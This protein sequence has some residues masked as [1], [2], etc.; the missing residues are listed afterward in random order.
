M[1]SFVKTVE[2]KILEGIKKLGYDT[3]KVL[4]SNSNKPELGQFQFNGVMAIA[5]R[6]GKNPVDLANALVEILKED[7]CFKS[8]SVAGPGF[9]NITFNDEYLINYMNL[10]LDDFDNFIDVEESKTIIIDY[11]GANAAKALHIGHMRSANIGE[12]LKRL[13]LVYKNNVI[14]DVHLGDVGRQSGMVISELQ[15]EQP[16]LPYFKEDYVE[17]NEPLNLTIE[18]LG[19]LYPTASNKAKEDESKMEEVRRITAEVDKGTKRYLD[20]WKKIVEIS[21]VQIKQVYDYL[22]CRFDLWE[23]E[24]DS[25]NYIDDTIKILKPY[26]YESEGAYVIDIKKEDDKLEIPPLIVIKT[27]GSTIYA[28]RDLAT[29][30]S[31]MT[32]F[33]PDEMWYFT[34]KRQGMYFEQCFRAAYKSGLVKEDTKLEFYGFGTM[35]GKDG[36]PFK[37][38]DGGVMTLDSLIEM[39]KEVA[40]T[41]LKDDVKGKEREDLVNKITVAILKFGD[42]LPVRNTDYNF[43]LDKVSSVEGKTGPYIL[44]TAVRIKSIFNKL[45]NVSDAKISV[46]SSKEEENIIIKLIELTKNLKSAYDEKNTGVIC[47]YLFNLCNLYNKFYSEH[48]IVNEKDEKV[49]ESWVALSKLVYQVIEK[50]LDILAIEI[51]DRM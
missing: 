46:I 27:D 17:C 9:I 48:N 8:L 26:M 21:S 11:G 44:Y 50:L 2:N 3:D 30:H 49:K 42:L 6:N 5:K 23:G 29:M 40:D 33:N 19:R 16:D 39:V 28:T 20:L 4:L 37:T 15:L 13:A 32:R 14:G 12:A 10:C 24:L 18:D 7:T 1:E 51:P 31:R 38:R 41:K 36:K 43:D 22:N 47:D 45:D 34:D 25:Y 35:N